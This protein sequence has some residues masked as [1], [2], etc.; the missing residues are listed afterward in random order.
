M[1]DKYE[2][3]KFV[4]GELEL[5]VRTDKEA[6]TVWLTQKEMA[7]LFD[8]S[9][10]NIG[11]HIRNIINDKELDVSTTEE[12]SVV[13]IEGN[14]EV[15]RKI[16]IYN[17]DMII[18]VGYRVK[19][20]RGIIFRRWA[21][22][23]LKNY[24]VEGYAINNKRMQALN[25]T[26]EIQSK[27]LANTLDVEA[28]ELENIINLYTNAF[29]LL[30]NYDH[31]CVEKP[32]GNKAEYT[33][34]YNECRTFIAGM[35]FIHDSNVFGVEKHQGQLEGI[36]ACINQTAFGEE[37]Y[38][39]LEE[40]AANLLYFIVKDHPFVD[41]CKRIAAGIFLL[42]L[43]KNALLT[44]NKPSISNGALT[45]I[46][47]LVAESKPEEKEVMVRIVMNILFNKM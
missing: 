43:S 42:Y 11:L 9:T 6:E 3:V 40:K 18:S 5:E 19:S 15:I 20:Q 12:S 22:K 41:G 7:I 14:R 36:I 27:M 29:T 25:R 10:D 17:L 33:L 30:D 34:T 13:Q 24:L 46:T 23:V 39:S 1:T 28:S 47:L 8:V 32:K 2:I 44:K 4:D 26:I 35:R 45:A 38:K 37:V 31:Q 16:K 21:N